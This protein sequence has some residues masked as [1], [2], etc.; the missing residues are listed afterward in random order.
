M[1]FK[2][3]KKKNSIFVIKKVKPF[4]SSP[5]LLNNIPDYIP[6]KKHKLNKFTLS[7]INF[8]TLCLTHKEILI[9]FM[10]M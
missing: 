7:M 6:V 4:F 2:S 8:V 1:S 3:Q 5:L 10:K 9:H